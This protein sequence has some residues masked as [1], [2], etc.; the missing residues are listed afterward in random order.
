MAGREFRPINNFDSKSIDGLITPHSI[1]ISI[2]KHKTDIF[3][4][5]IK[6]SK[7]GIKFIHNIV[8]SY[9]DNCGINV[10]YE[11]NKYNIILMNSIRNKDNVEITIDIVAEKNS[12]MDH[13]VKRT[14]IKKFFE[15]V[16]KIHIMSGKF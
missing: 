13:M 15:Y 8:N 4:R 12:K 9:G 11:T 7:I 3:I 5:T 2:N 6:D 16:H 10:E 1:E 14:F